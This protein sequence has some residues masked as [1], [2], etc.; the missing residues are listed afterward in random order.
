MQSAASGPIDFDN[1]PA[2]PPAGCVNDLLW[3][4]AYRLH[5]EHQPGADGWCVTCRPRQF[6]PCTGRRLAVFS[7]RTAHQSDDVLSEPVHRGYRW[8]SS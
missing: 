8:W 4:T 2:E 1:P 7:L 6:H 3:R 5:T